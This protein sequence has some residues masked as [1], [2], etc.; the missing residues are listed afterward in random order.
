[1]K[2]CFFRKD[3]FRTLKTFFVCGIIDT[4]DGAEMYKDIGIYVFPSGDKMRIFAFDGEKATE[5]PPLTYAEQL[6]DF[7]EID[8]SVLIKQV[9]NLKSY[10]DATVDEE[11]LTKIFYS[12]YHLAD[13]F[14]ED[15]PVY[16]FLMTNE[17]RHLD[18]KAVLFETVESAVLRKNRGLQVLEIMT[19]LQAYLFYLCNIYCMTDGNH[20]DKVR[21]VISNREQ[22]FSIWFQE[23]VS[24]SPPSI[25]MFEREEF[26]FPITKGYRF[27]ALQDYLW[28]VFINFLQYDVNFSECQHCG[29][30]FIPKTKRKTLYCDRI[31]TEGGRT[32]KDIG[33]AVVSK[34]N[35]EFS[36]VLAE[37]DKAVNRNFKRVERFEGK[38]S[39]EKKGKDLDYKDYSEW[40][41]RLHAVRE[42]WKNGEMDDAEMLKVIHELD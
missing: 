27:S 30:F 14:C 20:A 26:G 25:E 41:E 9:N 1:M 18:K 31:R 23:I 35:A 11:L 24:T 8:M 15:S 19:D 13:I 38:L 4:K 6:V 33:P 22:I 28:F 36:T 10:D 7:L 29:H 39:D 21:E 16:S 17:L 42:M 40:L 34:R 37:Y 2:L 12:I 32:C 3:P 5:Y